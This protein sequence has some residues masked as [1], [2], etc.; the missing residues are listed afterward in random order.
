MAEFTPGRAD[1]GPSGNQSKVW[2]WFKL[3]LALILVGFVV[4]KIQMDDLAI[5][6]GSVS[7]GWLPFCAFCFLGWIGIAA[8]RYWWLVGRTMPYPQ[9]ISVVVIQ[10]VVGNL[11]ATG[12]GLVSYLAIL[13]NRHQV[14]VG[15][16]M[17]SIILARFLDLVIFLPALV[18]SG[19][20]VWWEIGS[21]R[22]L[23]IILTSVLSGLVI[24]L[25]L[26]LL[27]RRRAA[28]PLRRLLGCLGV[29]GLAVAG[30]AMAAL[31]DLSRQ[32]PKML[33]GLWRPLAINTLLAMILSFGVFY[34]TVRFFSIPIGI[35]PML[36]MFT[37]TQL[38]MLV[39]IHVFGG[40]GV[41]DVPLLYLY[42]MFGFGQQVVAPV[43]IGGRLLLYLWNLLALLY[44][45]LEGRSNHKQR[46]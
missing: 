31:D 2:V 3:A 18:V 5:L 42:G 17:W 38:L 32:E 9:A 23:V 43:V 45:P 22:W 19:G 24:L 10:T 33:R 35:W 13:R 26:I 34:G 16:G 29:D 41:V 46:P 21:I 36:F 11:V 1:P 8:R 40:L 4:T 27:F 30:K 25:G 14:G 6:T 15:L 12:A 39:P 7:P 44:L 20:M 28:G 37:L